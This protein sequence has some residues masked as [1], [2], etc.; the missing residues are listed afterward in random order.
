MKK[1]II[2]LLSLAAISLLVAC[3][4]EDKDTNS[5]ATSLVSEQTLSSE[6]TDA[7]SEEGTSSEPGV[8]SEA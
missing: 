3:G 1:L 7:T 8:T 6:S 4:G 2:L 5:T